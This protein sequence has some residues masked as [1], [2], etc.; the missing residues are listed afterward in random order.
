MIFPIWQ[1]TTIYKCGW[2]GCE[3]SYGKLTH[4][5]VHVTTHSHGQKRMLEEFKEIRKEWEVRK[6]QLKVEE[7]GRA[8][9]A[10]PILLPPSYV[11]DSKYNPSLGH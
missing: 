10:K 2:N 3:K 1:S 7:F 8:T 5:N 6:N 9:T 11:V 4:L